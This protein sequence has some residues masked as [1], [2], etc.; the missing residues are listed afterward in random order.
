MYRRCLKEQFRAL[1][2]DALASIGSCHEGVSRRGDHASDE[3]HTSHIG[4]APTN[5]WSRSAVI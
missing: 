3:L 5:R 2:A 4:A 1:R